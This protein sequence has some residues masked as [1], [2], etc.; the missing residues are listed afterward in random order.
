MLSFDA[1]PIVDA[2][3]KPEIEKPADF[4]PWS[5]WPTDTVTVSAPMRSRQTNAT[6]HDA[7]PADTS[8]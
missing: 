6:V 4:S 5:V 8:T 7:L 2:A 3:I 1:T